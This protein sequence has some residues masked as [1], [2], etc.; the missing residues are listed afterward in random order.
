MKT[1][2]SIAALLTLVVLFVS[3]FSSVL[4]TEPLILNPVTWDTTGS[5]KDPVT[6]LT[7]TQGEEAKLSVTV[8]SPKQFDLSIDILTKTGTNVKNIN[9]PKIAANIV[10]VFLFTSSFMIFLLD[11]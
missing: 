10:V 2:K 11:V 9:F 3:T 8:T 7:V 1:Y 5:Q 6:D 4:A